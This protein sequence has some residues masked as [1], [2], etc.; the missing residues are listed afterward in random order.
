MIVSEKIRAICQ[1]MPDYADVIKRKGLGN[2]RAR[3]FV[4]IEALVGMFKV[5]LAEEQVRHIVRQ[6]FELKRVPLQLIPRIAEVRDFHSL[7]FAAVQATM[8]PGVK[9]EAFEYYHRFVVDQCKKLEPLW[10]V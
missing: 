8:K 5:D 3:D 4:D 9:L 6:M 7:G 10:H 1:Q 2:E